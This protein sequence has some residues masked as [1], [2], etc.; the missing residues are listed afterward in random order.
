MLS[1]VN[2]MKKKIINIV[3]S[4]CFMLMVMIVIF[5]FSSHA[6]T[7][8]MNDRNFVGDIIVNLFHINVPEGESAGTVAIIFGL[9]VGELAHIFIYAV[10]GLTSFFFVLTLF[11]LKKTK[12]ERDLLWISLSALAISFLYACSDEF[13]QMFVEGRFTSWRSIG[14][15]AIGFISMIIIITLIF[16]LVNLYKEKHKKEVTK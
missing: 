7:E 4:A 1:K 13:H 10:L 6:T 2:K 12:K 9:A 14:L 3:I 8:T 15:D 5:I 11:D 16:I